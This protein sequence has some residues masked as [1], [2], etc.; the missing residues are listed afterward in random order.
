MSYLI[1]FPDVINGFI[2][3]VPHLGQS[4]EPGFYRQTLFIIRDLFLKFLHKDGAFRPRADQAHFPFED[5]DKLR[6]FV[7]MR[8][9]QESADGDKPGIVILRPNG[10]GFLSASTRMVRNL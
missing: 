9:A 3:L 7:D 6:D 2:V 8:L 10:A 1:F 4:G 5:V